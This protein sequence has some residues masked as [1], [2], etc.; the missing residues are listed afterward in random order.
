MA[1]HS[2]LFHNIFRLTDN[3]YTLSLQFRTTEKILL[4]KKP[5]ASYIVVNSLN[6]NSAAISQSSKAALEKLELR[7]PERVKSSL[8]RQTTS[9]QH[10]QS[11]ESN[12]KSPARKKVYTSGVSLPTSRRQLLSPTKRFIDEKRQE[13]EEASAKRKRLEQ[14]SAKIRDAA[15]A[16]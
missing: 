6:H 14:T 16:L 12:L 11:P 3:F 9:T 7:T 1:L 2:N 4:I 10:L 5:R 15:S 8:N 13:L